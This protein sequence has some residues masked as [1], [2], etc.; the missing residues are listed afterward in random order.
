MSHDVGVAL[1][2]TTLP[3]TIIIVA[4]RIVAVVAEAIGK[5]ET[6]GVMC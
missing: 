3:S 4:P 2:P 6:A 1:R 5:H